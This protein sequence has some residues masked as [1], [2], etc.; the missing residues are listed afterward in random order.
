MSNTWGAASTADEVMAGVDLSGK[1]ALVTGASGGLGAETARVFA[2]AGA[3]VLMAARDAEKNAGAI[4]AIRAQLPAARLLPVA[5]DLADLDSVRR[6]AQTVLALQ[7][8]IDLL[9]NNAGIMWG[10][11][12]RTA[13]GC[14]LHF[15]TNHIGHFLLTLL[16]APALLAAAPARV[17]VLSSLAHKQASVDFDDPH[18]LRRPYEERLAY[19]QSK[20][21]NALFAVGLARRL[22]GFG[23]TANALHPGAIA[24]E[25]MRNMPAADLA[26]LEART[27]AAGVTLKTVAQ[28]AATQVWAAVAPELRDVS[29]RYLADCQVSEPDL[30]PALER[31]CLPHALD[32]VAAERLWELSESIVGERWRY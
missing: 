32:P 10:P 29:G 21:A 11:L 8:R 13:E 26:Q 18:Y 22:R 12:R 31:S 28:G 24:T 19:S 4:A 23:I 27:R 9:I 7:P 30:D 16:L 6:C 1:V 17:V 25:L 20:T 3:T 5:L 2:R 15:G 14:E